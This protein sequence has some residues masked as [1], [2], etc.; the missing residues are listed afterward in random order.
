LDI[1]R[2]IDYLSG[3][4]RQHGV[5]IN[6]HLNPTYV[7]FGTLLERKFR[8]GEYS[9]PRLRDV[10]RAALHAEAK[11]IS[12]FLG[13]SDEGLACA[14]GTFV[15]PG[16]EPLVEKLEAFNRSLNFDLLREVLQMTEPAAPP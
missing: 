10:A 12:I 13:L 5:R 16:E 9:P 2:A 15:R 6:L 8:Q 7:A 1:H 14:G 3:L 11:P 4:T